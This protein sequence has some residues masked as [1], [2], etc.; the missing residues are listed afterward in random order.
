MN[1]LAECEWQVERVEHTLRQGLVADLTAWMAWEQYA[2]SWMRLSKISRFPEDILESEIRKSIPNSGTFSQTI[3]ALYSMLNGRRV[4][5]EELCNCFLD[6]YDPFLKA[7][8][9]GLMRDRKVGAVYLGFKSYAVL[10]NLSFLPRRIFQRLLNYFC[11]GCF[12]YFAI[13]LATGILSCQLIPEWAQIDMIEILRSL[14][15][16]RSECANAKRDIQYR[17]K[18]LVLA[19]DSC[20]RLKQIFVQARERGT[21]PAWVVSLLKSQTRLP[22]DIVSDLSEYLPK[23]HQASRL[24]GWCNEDIT[25]ILASQMELDSRAVEKLRHLLVTPKS[26]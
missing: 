11:D 13:E 4:M 24:L 26:Y 9:S 2:P 19:P 8:S 3:E 6:L 20:R 12:N 18:I 21:S 1:C 25:K 5:S 23:G 15:S 16:S 17:L 7:S 22:P 10:A 14:Q